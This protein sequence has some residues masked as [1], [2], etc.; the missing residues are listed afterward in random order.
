MW[1][2]SASCALRPL[3]SLD[4]LLPLNALRALRALRASCTSLP[5]WSLRIRICV[6]I[7]ACLRVP[8]LPFAGSLV[9]LRYV[10][11]GS[12]DFCNLAI[13]CVLHRAHLCCS[14]RLH[15]RDNR[16]LHLSDC[17][18]RLRAAAG[19][20]SRMFLPLSL[21]VADSR[22]N[23]V[24]CA[25][26]SILGPCCRFA[27]L[28]RAGT[29]F[30]GA[31]SRIRLRCSRVVRVCKGSVRIA[32]RCICVSQ[33]IGFTLRGSIRA[34]LSFFCRIRYGFYVYRNRINI[35]LCSLR[36]SCGG[37]CAGFSSL[38][39]I[40]RRLRV[41]L[42]LRGNLVKLRYF[43]RCYFLRR[44]DCRKN[45]RFKDAALPDLCAVIILLRA[46]KL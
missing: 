41:R 38:R 4:S 8:Y 40:A 24:L 27:S 15:L 10:R 33:S 23:D 19:Y 14:R 12:I 42:H 20:S 11:V 7:R 9:D 28:C 45:A 2:R 26:R 25:R 17:L 1:P 6:Y 36:A 5:L 18:K 34:R 39:R 35:F 32:L 31:L 46:Y 44:I 29:C 22:I 30:T 37:A 43:F 21:D 13:S 16:L 3:F